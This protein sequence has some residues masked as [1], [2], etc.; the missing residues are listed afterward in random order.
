MNTIPHRQSTRLNH[1]RQHF[2]ILLVF[3]CALL[4]LSSSGRAAIYEWNDN[5]NST[6]KL[7]LYVPDGVQTIRGIVIYGNG[8]GIDNAPTATNVE[9]VAFARSIDFAVLGMGYWG[10]FNDPNEYPYFERQMNA[11]IMASQHP[12]MTNAPWIPLGHSNGG[13]ISSGLNILHPEKVIAFIISK[14]PSCLEPE[15]SESPALRTPGML[16]NGQ[17]DLPERKTFISTFFANNRE[18]GALWAWAEEAD[19]AHSENNTLELKLPFLYECCR[20][21]YPSYMSP[22]NGPVVLKD[23]N[24]FDGWLVDQRTWSNGLA[25]I[26]PYADA[27]G[28]KRSYGWVPNE[29]IAKLYQAFS[30]HNKPATAVG[31]NNK[32]GVA[33][34]NLV[35]TTTLVD[36][37]WT[38]VEFFRNTEKIGELTGGGVIAVG[39]TNLVEQGGYTVFHAEVTSPPTNLVRAT[40]LRRVFVIG[41]D[42]LTPF[43]QWAATNLPS[44][45]RGPGD[46]LYPEDGIANLTRYIFDLGTSRNPPRAALPKY[47]GLIQ[48]GGVTR[49]LFQ[50]RVG[51]AGR[52][53]GVT[54]RPS[55]ST[56]LQGWSPVRSP[57]FAVDPAGFWREG[58]TNYVLLPASSAGFLRLQLDDCF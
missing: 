2:P 20:L 38:T 40:Y 1:I 42:P 51:P 32:T 7:L 58:D 41:P 21:R 48:T 31:G 55:V 14:A 9:I 33:P 12:E 11:L 18:A 39:I 46:V 54:V 16:I 25:S 28:D 49:A 43:Q 6:R 24:E 35:F 22:T 37:N 8:G 26:Y 5:P 50:Y 23:L 13:S 3:A 30:S 56:N 36:T 15:A 47:T 19:L 4:G 45:S 57:V 10:C 27:P 29:Y 44:G 34:T 17:D 53:S 52:D